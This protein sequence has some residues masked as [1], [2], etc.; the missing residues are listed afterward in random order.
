MVGLQ[1]PLLIWFGQVGTLSAI[2]DGTPG[3]QGT[4]WGTARL[5]RLWPGQVAVS[6]R[7]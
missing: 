5:C 4:F 2:L 1:L 7:R 6:T 3:I